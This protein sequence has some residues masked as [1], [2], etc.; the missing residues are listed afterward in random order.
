MA[1]RNAFSLRFAVRALLLGLM[2]GVA[3]LAGACV[4]RGSIPAT[5]AETRPRSELSPVASVSPEIEVTVSPAPS[6]GLTPV[7]QVITLTLWIPDELYLEEQPGAK[8][9]ESIIEEFN[10]R[11]RIH[12]EPR[13]RRAYGDGSAVELMLTASEV[14]PAILPDVVILDAR[15]VP[16]LVEKGLLRSMKGLLDGALPD[17]LFPFA[18]RVGAR[19]DNWF[20]VYVCADVEHLAYNTAKVKSPP[21]TWDQLLEGVGGEYLFPAKGVS[22]KANN[23]L[24]I[25]YLAA[26][27]RVF[28]DE[29]SPVLDRDPL[30]EVLK[31][32]RRGLEK[33][34]ISRL[35][36][37][38][39]SVSECWKIYLAA[40]VAMVNVRSSLFLADRKLLRSTSFAPL[41][42][43][44]G[45]VATVADGWAIA[46]VAEDPARQE[47]AAGFVSW[48]LS[49]E[50]NARWA[51]DAG[52]LPVRRD[53]F[54]GEEDPYIPFLRWQLESAWPAPGGAEFEK[55]ATAMQGALDKVLADEATPESA[56]AEAVQSLKER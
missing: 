16:E 29:G 21:L 26:G 56:A 4:K 34:V 40:K 14:A 41:P 11:G 3:F 12:V 10:A 20:A 43:K 6:P 13:V 53:A 42:T 25:Q 35:A 47:A 32:Y 38:L 1:K 50:N 39:S 54:A 49:S 7:P 15:Q 8:T 9:L 19:G 37:S 22:G 30:V 2:V 51:W 18:V 46:I 17:E 31:F 24:L 5:P 28:D 45:Q 48:L 52:C 27:G 33:G 23:A 44:K 36:P 55:V